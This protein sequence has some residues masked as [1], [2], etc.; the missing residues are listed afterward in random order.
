MKYILV[1][2]PEGSQPGVPDPEENGAVIAVL[3]EG[4]HS[5]D[6]QAY[7]GTVDDDGKFRGGS[8]GFKAEAAAWEVRP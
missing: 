8:A 1:A 5:L 4:T 2:V 6:V 3:P 7:W